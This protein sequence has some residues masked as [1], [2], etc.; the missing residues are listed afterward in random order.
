MSR[1]KCLKVTS[2][3]NAVDRPDETFGPAE[4]TRIDT[5]NVRSRTALTVPPDTVFLTDLP[6]EMSVLVPP[7]TIDPPFTYYGAVKHHID[8]LAMEP[9]LRVLIP[10]ALDPDVLVD[11]HDFD[12]ARSLLLLGDDRRG[13]ILANVEEVVQSLLA[14]FREASVHLVGNHFIGSALHGEKLA[15]RSLVNFQRQ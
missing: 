8:L 5:N 14:L 15:L 12:V 3:P 9:R 11:D 1:S 13:L 7:Q 4:P 2:S 10:V 6:I